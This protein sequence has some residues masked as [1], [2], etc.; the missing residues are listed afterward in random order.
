SHEV[1]QGYR[2]VSDPSVY[3][4]LPVTRGAGPVRP[5]D[6]LVVW[7]TTPWTLVSNAAVAVNPELEYVR[8][9]RASDGEQGPVFVVARAVVGTLLGEDAEVLERFPGSELPG[10][11]YQGPFEFIAAEAYGERGRTVLPA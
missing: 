6:E 2:D 4:R 10:A 3:V 8:A 11:A 9:R 7:T 1:A 5:G